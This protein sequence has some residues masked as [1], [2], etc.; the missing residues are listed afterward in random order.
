[1]A[2]P[3]I[4]QPIRQVSEGDCALCSL[5]MI[6]GKSYQEVSA[7]ASSFIVKPHK[8]GLGTGEIKKIALK[9][10]AKLTST[11]TKGLPLDEETGI[12]LVRFPDKIEHAVVLFQGVIY[13]PYDGL[14]YDSTTYLSSKN[15]HPLNLLRP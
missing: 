10:G 12:F 2:A 15:A 11:K 6:L 13:D 4:I 3:A 8:N 1:M 14:L 5:A 9:L 7:A